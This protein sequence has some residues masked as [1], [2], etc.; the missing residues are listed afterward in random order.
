MPVCRPPAA[1]GPEGQPGLSG[2]PPC[3]GGQT[4]GAQP[5][6]ASRSPHC[7]EPA[8]RGCRLGCW[9]SGSAPCDRHATLQLHPRREPS[10]P[11]HLPSLRRPRPGAGKCDGRKS[12][13]GGL[14]ADQARGSL[15]ITCRRWR[16]H[17]RSP[18]EGQALSTRFRAHDPGAKVCPRPRRACRRNPLVPSALATMAAGCLRPAA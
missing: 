6:S 17:H 10:P 9:S 3:P 13:G 15:R 12:E 2:R 1:L 16:G 8:R 5:E 7:P 4:P 14:A 18:P 11:G